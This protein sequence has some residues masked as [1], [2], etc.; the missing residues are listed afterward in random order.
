MVRL[1]NVKNYIKNEIPDVADKIQLGGINGNRLEFIGV[2]PENSSA[3]IGV[4]VGGLSN[5]ETD[6][7]YC[8]ILVHYSKSFL[9][10]EEM[11]KQI[12]GLFLAKTNIDIDGETA[13]YCKPSQIRWQGKDRYGVYEFAFTVQI[14]GERDRL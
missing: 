4:A 2:Y 8:K 9:V 6:I 10:C 3:D 11:A 13:Y 14:Y 7:M 5:T 1:I 12:H